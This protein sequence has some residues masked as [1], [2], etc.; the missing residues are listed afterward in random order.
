MVAQAKHATVRPLHPGMQVSGD[1]YKGAFQPSTYAVLV[2]QR[3]FD[4]LKQLI[5]N[6]KVL[7]VLNALLVVP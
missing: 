1:W 6:Q 2:K 3:L 5:L 4:V 7:V